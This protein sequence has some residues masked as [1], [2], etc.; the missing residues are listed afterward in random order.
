MDYNIQYSENDIEIVRNDTIDFAYT[1]TLN[2]VAC[3]LTGKRID[4]KVKDKSGTVVKTLSSAGTS[5]A[6]VISTSIFRVQTSPI[7]VT[8]V[9]RYDVQLTTGSVIETIQ[10]GIIN[11][12]EDIT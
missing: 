12:I 7:T 11:V 3:N 9:Y 6:I 1:V 4:I 8:G 2:G 10:R 5:P